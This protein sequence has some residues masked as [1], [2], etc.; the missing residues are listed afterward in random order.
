MR[1]NFQETNLELTLSSKNGIISFDKYGQFLTV[2]IDN[3]LIFY[4]GKSF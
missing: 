3:K 2:A 1:K 4:G